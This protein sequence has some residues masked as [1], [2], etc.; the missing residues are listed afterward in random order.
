MRSR[1]DKTHWQGRFEEAM[2]LK[3]DS[4]RARR[5]NKRTIQLTAFGETKCFAEW[6]RDSRCLVKIDSLRDRLDKGW[7]AE[8][9]IS[10][11]PTRNGKNTK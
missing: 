11:P 10:F 7:N 1:M 4:D 5:N 6:L 3:D 8:K 2:T 9:A